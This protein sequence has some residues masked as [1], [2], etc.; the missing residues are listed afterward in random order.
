M[1]N[2]DIPNMMSKQ[3]QFNQVWQTIDKKYCDSFSELWIKRALKWIDMHRFS[4]NSVWLLDYSG[5]WTVDSAAISE[6]L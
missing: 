5:Q 1:H 3:K 2:F 4:L 6:E